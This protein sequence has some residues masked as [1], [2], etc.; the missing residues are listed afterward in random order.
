MPSLSLIRISTF[1]LLA[2]SLGLVG[3]GSN[4]TSVVSSAP[5][6]TSGVALQGGVH[7]GQQPVVGATLQLYASSVA[8]YGA[9]SF[10]LL[11]TPVTTNAQGAF[12]IT[13]DYTCPSATSQVYLVATGGNPG[14]GA[15][16]P[17]LAMMAALGP[18][19]NLTP[20]TFINI[21][22]VTTVATVFAV[23]PFMSSYS[24]IGSS[25]ANTAGLAN[26]FAAVNKVANY[27]TGTAPGPALPS[28]AVLPISEINSLADIIAACVNSNGGAAGDTSTCGTLFANATPAGGTAPTDTIGAMLDIARNPGRN[29]SA[30]LGLVTPSA[31][32]QPTLAAANDFTIAIKYKTGGFSTPSAS[33]VDQSGN[34]WVANAGNNTLTVLASSGSPVGASPYSGGGLSG[35]SGVAIDA[36]GNAWVTDKTS[37]K[38]SVFTAA[39]PR[40]PRPP[41]PGS[42]PPPQSPSMA[43]ASSGS[44][45]P[46]AT[47]SPP[48]VPPAPPSTPPPTL[49][50]SVGSTPRSPSPSTPNNR[51]ARR[52]SRPNP[53]AA[54]SGPRLHAH[55]FI[56]S[57]PL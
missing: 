6:V 53:G 46:A 20:S 38:L 48:S 36:S 44:P 21:N 11:N 13:G 42:V 24:A 2:S 43:R 55:N 40:E 41:S 14:T 31:P 9:G 47:P 25:A 8:G 10:A 35:P 45:T 4:F 34:I 19:G 57:H 7:G 28:G 5:I 39:G 1:G 15:V 16:N 3:C 26:A 12:T 30:L 50:A 32:F 49:P 33:A 56:H 23:A 51:T 22:E 37:S 52:D 54:F 29:V 27:T 17:N 18:C